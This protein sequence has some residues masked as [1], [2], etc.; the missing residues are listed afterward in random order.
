MQV[1]TSYHQYDDTKSIVKLA[2]G[3]TNTSGG[4]KNSW[5]VS[6][7]ADSMPQALLNSLELMNKLQ[8]QIDKA[9]IQTE[10]MLRDEVASLEGKLFREAYFDDS[11]KKLFVFGHGEVR[12]GRARSEDE[13][14]RLIKQG[15][16][17]GD[18]AYVVSRW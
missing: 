16:K 8:E 9:V 10:K 18:I 6:T 2:L 17:S 5:Q 13:Y 3:D 14:D 15:I 4:D 12:L 11:I 7:G 1:S